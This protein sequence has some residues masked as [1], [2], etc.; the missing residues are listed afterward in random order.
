MNLRKRSILFFPF[1]ART[2]QQYKSR[3]Y[4]PYRSSFPISDAHSSSSQCSPLQAPLCQIMILYRITAQI[5]I[6]ISK[7]P[8]RKLLNAPTEKSQ[9]QL[10][11]EQDLRFFSIP[12]LPFLLQIIQVIQSNMQ[13]STVRSQ[14]TERLL[15]VPAPPYF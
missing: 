2:T 12:A 15:Q 9:F 1:T 5:T 6:D 10:M 3:Q 13:R 11:P 7:F 4:H 8:C 14:S